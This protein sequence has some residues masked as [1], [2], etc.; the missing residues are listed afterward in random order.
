MGQIGQ[1][2]SLE[3][4][5]KHIGQ[6]SP[7]PILLLHHHHH[8]HGAKRSAVASRR[9]DLPPKRSVPSQLESTPPVG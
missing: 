2:Y 5:H 3:I 8:H 1:Q 6:V 9:C 7:L 4:G